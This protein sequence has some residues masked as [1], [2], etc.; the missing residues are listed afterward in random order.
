MIDYRLNTFLNLCDTLNYTITAKNLHMTQPA[1]TQHIQFLEE[2][3]KVELFIYENRKLHLTEAGKKLYDYAISLKIDSE[4]IEKSLMKIDFGIS[5]LKFGATLTIGEYI[6]P[7][8]LSVLKKENPKLNIS[9]R[10]ANTENL[11]KLLHQGVIDFAIIEGHFN[12]LEY[13]YFLFSNE[14]F[15]GVRKKSEKLNSYKLK[16]LYTENLIVRERGSGTR[17]ILEQILYE[18]NLNMENFN[19]IMQIGNINAIKKMVENDLG[20]TFLYEKAVEKKI[21]DNKLE[22]INIENFNMTR[23]FNFIFLKD[24]YFYE[25]YKKWYDSFI[26]IFNKNSKKL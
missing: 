1:V 7:E 26:E 4:K 8:I 2:H 10:V 14:K 17:E 20:I 6:M 24:S 11:I 21:L 3:Y 5:E 12:K 16:E 13:E 23:E 25:E 18:Q 9:M 19:Q 15:I 22:E